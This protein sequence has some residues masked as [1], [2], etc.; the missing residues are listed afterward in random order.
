MI[1]LAARPGHALDLV[2]EACERTTGTVKARGEHAFMARCPLH[3]DNTPSLSV[4]W[5]PARSGDAGGAVFLHCFS[6]D[7]SAEFITA[8]LAL[9]VS[10]LFDN[11]LPETNAK[12]IRQARV[13]RPPRP[14]IQVAAQRPRKPDS[15]HHWQRVRVYTYTTVAGLPVQQV[16]RQECHCDGTRHK[17]FV[18]RYRHG[19]NWEWNAPEGFTPVLYRSRELHRAD[20]NDWVW[21]T[22]GEKDAETAAR[23]G[24]VATTNANGSGGF[25]DTLAEQ[26]RGRKVALVV[27]RDRAGYQRAATVYSQLQPY[28][29]EL[30]ILLPAIHTPKADL[31]D[32]VE[33]GHWDSAD[34]FGGMTVTDLDELAN[35][36]AATQQPA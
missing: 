18:Q 4:R 34:E 17:R 33:T 2:R 25:P 23:L 11:P 9:K 16:I 8:A 7:A 1:A 14:A 24:Q 28:A 27:D 21:L 12:T 35:H 31:T 19:R 6:C 3:Q 26:L 20:A 32:H 15:D 5:K 29:A 30:V 10:D 22:E 13:P 36:L